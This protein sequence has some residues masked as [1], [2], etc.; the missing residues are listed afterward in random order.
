VVTKDHFKSKKFTVKENSH[1]LR[2]DRNVNQPFKP[3][4]PNF[5]YI[6]ARTANPATKLLEK[7]NNDAA[8][9]KEFKE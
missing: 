2:Y 1:I 3:E 9:M 5:P 4:T 7:Y 8:R 6:S